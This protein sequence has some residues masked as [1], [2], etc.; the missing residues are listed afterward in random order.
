M[1]F[2]S[3]ST[4]TLETKWR[5]VKNNTGRLKNECT[6]LIAKSSITRKEV[7]EFANAL[8]TVLANLDLLT[9][10]A[11][12]N[13]LLAYAQEQE[14][15]ASLNLVS[16]YTTMR[17]QIIAV[18][19]WT[20]TNFPNTSGELRAYVFDAQSRHVDINLDAGQLTAFKTQ[21][22]NLSATIA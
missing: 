16:E 15:N 12:T 2:P 3:D 9:A 1:A 6:R 18:Q 8:A 20:V 22:S 14:S 5:S 17:N 21:V 7:L 19:N 11:S 13:G 10:N 4:T